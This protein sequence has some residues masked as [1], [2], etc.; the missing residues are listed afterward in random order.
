MILGLYIQKGDFSIVM[1]IRITSKQLAKSIHV[2]HVFGMPFGKAN[3]SQI[4]LVTN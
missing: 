4:T 3:H 1:V 2:S